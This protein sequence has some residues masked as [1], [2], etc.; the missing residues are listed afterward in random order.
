MPYDRERHGPRRMVGPGFH[1]L[2]FDA[3]REIPR[4]YVSTYGDVAAKLGLRTA[5][6]LVGYALSAIPAQAPDVPW[7]RVVNAQGRVSSRAETGTPAR[8]IA[9]LRSEGVKI[10]SSGSIQ[11][12]EALRWRFP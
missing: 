6:R 2:V 10:S 7:H 1:A 9:R 5:A 12:F 8:Q 4:G 3:V 11:D